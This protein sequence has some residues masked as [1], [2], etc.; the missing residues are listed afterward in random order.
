MIY[1]N[2]GMKKI[3]KALPLLLLAFSF[4][5]SYSQNLAI[6]QWK[7][8]LP[9]N[10]G[11]LVTEG[12]NTIICGAE[13]GIFIYNKSDNSLQ[14]ITKVNGLSDINLALLRYFP[15][16]DILLVGYEDGNIDLIQNGNVYNISDIQRKNILG[17]KRIN[18]VMFFQQYAY[19]ACNFGIV[20]LNLD[21]K[22]IKDSYYL[23]Y[24]TSNN[25]VYGVTTDGNNLFAATDSGIY[26]VNL[27]DAN[28]NYF[29]SWNN[30]TGNLNL[31]LVSYNQIF[32]YSNKLYV[33][34][35]PSSSIF[36]FDNSIWSP[37]TLGVYDVKSVQV[38]HNKL[39]V[40][41]SVDVK[42]FNTTLQEEMHFSN[43]T[44]FS[45]MRDAITDQ[46]GS[47]W[48]ADN[49]K[50]LAKVSTNSSFEFFVPDG[51]RSNKA[52]TMQIVNSQ[53]WV[54]HSGV[55]SNR[56]DPVYSTDGFSTYVN[57]KWATYDH[58]N[59]HSP[60][61]SLDT[62]LDFMS[63]AVDPRNSNHVF[64]GSR[65]KGVVEFD[66]GTGTVKNYFSAFNSTIQ[67]IPNYPGTFWMGGIAFDVNYNVWMLNSNVPS[68]LL[69]Y[70]TDGTWKSYSFPGFATT[71]ILLGDLMFDSYGQIWIDVLGRGIIVGQPDQVS[72]NDFI[73]DTSSTTGLP[74]NDVRVFM[75]DKE[76]QVWIGTAKG[77]AVVYSPGTNPQKILLLQD[78][79]YQYLLGTEGVTSIAID[80][81]NR[82]WFGT[83]NAGVFLMSA[84]GTKQLQHFTAENSPLLSNSILSIAI[85]QQTGE[86]FFGTE[87]G[88]VSYKGDATEGGDKC[89]NTYVYPNPVKHEYEGPIAITGLVKNGN[90]KI[91][92]ISGTLVYETTALGGQ[93]IWNGKNFAGTKAH[94]GVYLVFCSDEDGKNTCI[95]K[96]LLI[97]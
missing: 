1:Y 71:G 21:R 49:N 92:D 29:G 30:I 24:T 66:N 18:A 44:I 45:V 81:A 73:S 70:Q 94:T 7:A 63:L 6:G 82:K 60:L 64:L 56:W 68:A 55:K 25:S 47:L 57:N 46:S 72:G 33:L 16:K 67:T 69:V 36:A 12:N 41:G 11:R 87:R 85:N 59:V 34:Q 40:T 4:S 39:V 2:S 26:S 37:T 86:I 20:V 79:T 74:S 15:E 8:H 61:V 58:T 88:I 84:D 75:E 23:S 97:N 89:E 17:S 52:T 77:V 27:F 19:L 3:L 13:D 5:G 48:I 35:Q 14:T 62:V 76:G 83:E 43:P 38:T 54:G 51:P 42:I 28:I 96:L 31:T 22:E 53:L 78:G 91:T 50:G 93:A 9:F 32:W 95:T 10:K 80:G 90:V 65:G